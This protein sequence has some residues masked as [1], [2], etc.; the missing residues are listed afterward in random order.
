MRAGWILTAVLLTL[1]PLATNP[2]RAAD[3]PSWPRFHG[4]S[5]D[6]LSTETG[7]LKAWPE[8]GP[9][10]V[11]TATGMGEGYSGVALAGGKIYTAGNVGGKTVVTALDLDGKT[12]WQAECGKPWTSGPGGTRS[13]PTIEGDRL[14]YETPY[15][16]V[17]CLDAGTGEEIWT[18]NIL[19]RF[20]SKNITW[21]LAESLIVDGD[22]IICLPGGPKASVVALDKTTGETVWAAASADEDLAGYATLSLVEQDGLR[23]ILTMTAKA[24]IGINADGGELLFR[25]PHKTNYDV[26]AT[27]PIYHDGQIFITSGYGTTG[28][29][30]VRLTVDGAR[31]SVEKVW[32]SRE[33]DNHHGGVILLDGYIYG[34]AHNFNSGKWIC[35]DWK[36]GEMKY[37]ERGVG[38]GSLTYADGMLYT[39]SEKRD[40]GLVPATPAAHEVVSSFKTPSGPDGP[41]WAHPVVCGGRLYL[42]H[43]DNLYAYNVSAE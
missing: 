14:Y 6:N 9:P 8:D 3:A 31:A 4:P 38:K 32:E 18:V 15:G 34:A 42:R 35:L 37:A 7:L 41:T 17:Y 1:T 33:L 28:S 30:M 39:Y 27:T 24:L 29:V 25:F 40:V 23:I 11:W 21:S 5:G 16:D 26:N 43:G 2:A 22:R 13:T 10:L 12:L 19:D 36:T 20:S